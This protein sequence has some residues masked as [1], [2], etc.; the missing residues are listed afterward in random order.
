VVVN[1]TDIDKIGDNQYGERYNIGNN[2]YSSKHLSYCP[3]H[4]FLESITTLS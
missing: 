3:I 4:R 2:Q 1:L